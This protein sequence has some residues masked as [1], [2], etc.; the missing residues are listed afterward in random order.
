MVSNSAVICIS[1]NSYDMVSSPSHKPVTLS[2]TQ[3]QTQTQTQSQT[4]STVFSARALKKH[5]SN[6][7]IFLFTHATGENYDRVGLCLGLCLGL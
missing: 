6:Y 3:S 1:V 4:T 7:R 2:H 5:N